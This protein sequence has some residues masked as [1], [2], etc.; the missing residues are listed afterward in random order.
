M[1][2]P[3]RCCT[4]VC[5]DCLE[6]MKA[7]PDGCV[8]AV[9]TDPPYEIVAAGGGL[10]KKRGYEKA[11]CGLTEGFDVSILR[12]FDN[13]MCFCSKAQL[14]ALLALASETDR[15]MLLTWNKPDPTP[16]CN[17]NYLPDT[18]YIVHHF[19][20]VYGDYHDKSRFWS[21]IGGSKE[22][23]PTGKPIALM[24]KCVR[25]ATSEAET[26]LDP[27]LGSGTTAVA[28]KKLGSGTV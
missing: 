3:Y 23:H 10:G 28:A 19:M 1:I 14:L 7:L 22:F 8:D 20:R 13:W 27:F 21:G 17:G 26:I 4:V 16:L 9:I 5:G 24:E 11:L 18:E 15:W 6:L 2:G 25:L 12:R